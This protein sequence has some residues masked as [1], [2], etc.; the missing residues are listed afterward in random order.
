MQRNL[1]HFYLLLTLPR[2]PLVVMTPKSL[3]RHPECRSSFDL[4]SEDSEFQRMILDDGPASKNPA[5]VQKILFCT[6]KVGYRA[7]ASVV[8]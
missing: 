4:L 2:K 5:A 8:F 6:G 7:S 3:L 1:L